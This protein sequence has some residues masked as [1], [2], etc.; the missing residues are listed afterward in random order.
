M[1]VCIVPNSHVRAYACVTTVRRSRFN[2]VYTVVDHADEAARLAQADAV[3][4]FLCVVDG[5]DANQTHQLFAAAQQHGLSVGRTML[6]E[7]ITS[8]LPEMAPSTR[9]RLLM[10]VVAMSA[11][12]R[13]GAFERALESTFRNAEVVTATP[14]EIE[15]VFSSCTSPPVSEAYTLCLVKPH[16]LRENN[17]AALLRSIAEVLAT[18]TCQHGSVC[19]M[20]LVCWIVQRGFDVVGLQKFHL[21]GSMAESFF[22]VYKVREMSINTWPRCTA[23]NI[24]LVQSARGLSPTTRNTLPKRAPGHPSR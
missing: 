18:A 10:E 24:L 15:Q 9:P 12:P 17:T 21:N 6:A 8:P 4:H 14:I 22:G 16:I 2:R 1:Y 5:T 11:S 23:L 19:L 13:L 20:L 7:S 3:W